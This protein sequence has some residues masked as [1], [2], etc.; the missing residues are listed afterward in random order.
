MVLNNQKKIIHPS[1]CTIKERVTTI[2]PQENEKVMK[3]LPQGGKRY[4]R[5]KHRMQ[6]AVEFISQVVAPKRI[7][8][9]EG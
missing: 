8:C 5:S 1:Q 2:I 7:Y 6:P 9:I 3:V 4:K